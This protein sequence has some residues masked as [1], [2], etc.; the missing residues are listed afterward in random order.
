ARLDHETFL[1]RIDDRRRVRRVDTVLEDR[2][3]GALHE[4]LEDHSLATV[5]ERFDLDL[6][7]RA[8]GERVEIVDAGDDLALAG[9]EPTTE[10]VGRERLVVRHRQPDTDAAAL[11]DV[12]A[13]PRELAERGDDLTEVAGHAHR[14]ELADRQRLRLL[15]HDL[16]LELGVEWV[17]GADLRPETILERGDD[18]AA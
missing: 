15:A 14:G 6:A 4:V 16:V 2:Q 18:A 13:G 5:L 12:V 1:E 10:R 17:V 8:R 3:H 9:P 7:D 11:V